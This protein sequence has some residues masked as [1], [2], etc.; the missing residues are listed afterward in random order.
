MKVHTKFTAKSG[1][2][3][4]LIEEWN[5]ATP[6]VIANGYDIEKQTWV[7][8][9]YFTD[10]DSAWIEFLSKISERKEV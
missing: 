7:S 9:N 2:C 6:Y 4:A 8:G 3:I 5:E 1:Y 10:L